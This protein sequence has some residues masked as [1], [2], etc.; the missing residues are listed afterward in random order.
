MDALNRKWNGKPFS[1]M[2][3]KLGSPHHETSH[4]DGEK[5]YT[6]RY[7]P[8][9]VFDDIFRGEF[10]SDMSTIRIQENLAREEQS[11]CLLDVFV[12]DGRIVRLDAEGLGCRDIRERLG[13]E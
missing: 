3:E 13:E 9:P 5:Q 6:Y 2:V 1:I 12:K 8:K 7:T 10:M 4:P 11:K